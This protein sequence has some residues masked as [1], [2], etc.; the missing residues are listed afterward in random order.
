MICF[1]IY[2]ELAGENNDM[3]NRKTECGQAAK[4]T[5]VCPTIKMMK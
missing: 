4:H 3:D 2:Q 1:S 5:C